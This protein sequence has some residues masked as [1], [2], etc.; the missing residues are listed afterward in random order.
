MI[1]SLTDRVHPWLRPRNFGGICSFQTFQKL[2]LLIA[3]TMRSRLGL[4]D[5]DMRKQAELVKLLES[6]PSPTWSIDSKETTPE[7]IREDNVDETAHW[8]SLCQ[9]NRQRLLD[10]GTTTVELEE[11][12]S[13]NPDAD[14]WRLEAELYD[15]EF[16]RLQ[17]LRQPQIR[18]LK[19]TRLLHEKS[20]S[21]SKDDHISSRLRKRASCDS[22]VSKTSRGA[23]A[24]NGRKNCSRG[25]TNT[26]PRRGTKSK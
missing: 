7:Y 1:G 26:R 19:T 6:K 17:Q 22:K 5:T 23:L 9:L 24:G 13:S 8:K 12:R 21:S 10:S 2:H 11:I 15:A 3:R 16:W 18:R 25:G 20:K 4:L 14:Y